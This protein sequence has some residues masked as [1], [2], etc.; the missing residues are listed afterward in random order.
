TIASAIKCL[1]DNGIIHRDLHSRNV[2]IHN[3]NIKL[4]DFGISKSLSEPSNSGLKLYG[5]LQYSDPQYLKNPNGYTRN[6]KSDIYSIGILFWEISSGKVPF[7]S[8]TSAGFSFVFSIVN[9]KREKI[10]EGSP[11]KYV[12]IYTKVVNNLDDVDITDTVNNIIPLP[13]PFDINNH[14][15]EQH[16]N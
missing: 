1:H 14:N 9:G 7:E 10:I 5:T 6:K 16:E 11:R 12:E 3:E 4:C 13:K 8:E 2:L 15:R